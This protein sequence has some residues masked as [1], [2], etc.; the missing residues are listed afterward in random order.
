MVSNYLSEKSQHL[1]PVT[2]EVKNCPAA[3]TLLLMR[4]W[5]WQ[6]LVEEETMGVFFSFW[7]SYQLSEAKPLCLPIWP[8]ICE[9]C[10]QP[11]QI[12][13]KKLSNPHSQLISPN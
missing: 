3:V 10:S 12:L 6:K 5:K 7:I 8:Y 9:S 2:Q 13:L 1:Y 11:A 4:L